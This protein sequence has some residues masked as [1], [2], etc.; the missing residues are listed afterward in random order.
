M[1][2][3]WLAWLIIIITS[4]LSCR[5]HHK[6]QSNEPTCLVTNKNIQRQCLVLVLYLTFSSFSSTI[7]CL[8]YFY[9]LFLLFQ[10]VIIFVLVDD[11]ESFLFNPTVRFM[12]FDNILI[13]CLLSSLLFKNK[14][15]LYSFFKCHELLRSLVTAFV[16]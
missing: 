5:L 15:K 9:C 10:N 6:I 8:F 1:N 3:C 7:Y 13:L 12:V 14:N 11:N 4:T 16:L 2:A